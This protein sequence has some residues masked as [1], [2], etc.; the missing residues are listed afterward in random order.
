MALLT[1]EVQQG[2]KSL[3][4]EEG[5]VSSAVIDKYEKLSNKDGTPF[6]GNLLKDGIVSDETMTHCIAYVSG[7]P[8][9]NLADV[10]IDQ[11][12]LSML[13]LEIAERFMAVPLGEVSGRLAVAMLDANN[14]QAV[15]FL[16]NK[17]ARPLKVYMASEI[18]IRNV[19]AQYKTDFSSVDAAVDAVDAEKQQAAISSDVKTIVQ[20]SP[21]SRALSTILEHAARSKASDIHIEP[22]ETQLLIRNRVD[23]VL[24]EIMQLPKSIEPALVSRIKI[25]AN[26]KI[27]EHRV[28]QDGQFAVVAAG[29]EIDLRIAISPVVWGE[30]VVIRLLDKTGNSFNIEEMGYAGRALR[31]IRKGIR[32]PNGMIITSGPTGSGK[33]TSLYALVQ[34]IKNDSINIVTLEDPVE[35]KMKGVNQIQVN[36][37]VGLTFANGLRSILRQ[38]PDVVM[39][40]EI[41]DKETA[42]L[43]VQAALT[44]HLVLTT[45]HTNSAA[46]VLP[47]L[48]DMGIE[49]FLIAS[50]VNTIIGQR[51][52]RRVST[53]RSNYQSNEIETKSI[54]DNIGP[55][56]PKTKGDTAAVS[57]DLGYEDLPLATQNA[58]TLA[59]GVDSPRSP[60]GYSGR[61]GLYEV[62]DM[63]EEI[64]NLVIQ[65]ATSPQI[66]KLAISQ[67]LVTMRQDG[68]FK[69]LQGLTTIDEVNR[70]SAG[71]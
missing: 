6:V 18:G 9:V 47:R 52:V 41:R 28:P 64:Q 16:A 39:V 23:G 31:T 54:L 2:L 13:P 19:I 14:I 71:L 37:D 3:L 45:L 11:K 25:L 44:G 30:Q 70:V 59:K 33:S 22:M 68:Y 12:I 1:N 48:L 62:I 69:V 15:D 56:L 21:I 63:T 29:K 8:Y 24:R 42:E 34:E 35:Y 53:E 5:L 61:V 55:L 40:G 26:L 60:G 65:R 58:Y 10:P 43:A 51:L 38:D 67:G 49:P 32:K 50:T 27:D 20:D 7:V 46:G 66:E 36:A 17:I 57:Q 4:A